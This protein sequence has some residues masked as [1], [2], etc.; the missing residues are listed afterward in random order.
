MQESPL[1]PSDAISDDAARAELTRNAT[2][3][4]GPRSLGA[5][6]A[7]RRLGRGFIAALQNVFGQH[8]ATTRAAGS[9]ASLDVQSPADLRGGLNFRTRI[10]VR[11]HAMLEKPTIV[12]QRGW[13]ESMSVNSIVPN[14]AQ[15]NSRDGS[16][17]MTFAP[18]AAG[19]SLAVWLYFQVNPTNLAKHSQ[20]EELDDGTRSLA[21]VHRSLTVWP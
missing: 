21:T 13:F 19:Q 12:M 2:S 9:R 15:Q 14:P 11:A 20:D 8:P 17:R 4:P 16:V 6:R 18:L 1:T 3:R 7:P 5:T 10:T